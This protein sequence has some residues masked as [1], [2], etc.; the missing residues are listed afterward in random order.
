MLKVGI[1]GGIGT[2]KSVVC[3]VFKTLGIPVFDADHETKQ[4]METDKQLVAGISRLFGDSI[5]ANN[6]LDREQL[7]AIVFNDSEKLKALN[8]IVH[9]ATIAHGKE[10]MAKQVTPYAIK[11]AAIFFESGSHKEMDIMIG[12]T[13]PIELR[14]R[15]LLQR[16]G[17]TRE[18]IESRMASQMENEK[19][20]ALCDYVVGNDEHTALIPQVM[21]LHTI[22]LK[23]VNG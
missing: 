5:Y 3:Q 4:L 14:V 17:M 2:G 11:E 18:K 7:A 13:A 10:W 9:P 12:V 6:K 16:A 23:K 22:L 21:K 8:A 15:R 1:T 20:M 19:K